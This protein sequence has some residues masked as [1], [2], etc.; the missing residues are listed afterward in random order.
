MQEDPVIRPLALH[1]HEDHLADPDAR[2]QA[3]RAL[4]VSRARRPISVHPDHARFPQNEDTAPSRQSEA[5]R[6]FVET[7]LIGGT[8]PKGK[9]TDIPNEQTLEEL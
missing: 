4:R 3:D 6:R 9:K 7:A 2:V 1:A 5:C 8:T